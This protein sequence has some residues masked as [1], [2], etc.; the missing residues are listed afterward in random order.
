MVAMIDWHSHILPGMDDGSRSVEE[1]LG[2]VAMQAAQGIKTVIATPH[3]YAN[4]E[5]VE[6]FLSRRQKAFAEL[7]ANLPE[8]SPEILLGAEIRYYPGIS[9]M[10]DLEALGIGE[11]NLLLLEMPM[12]Q[13]TEYSLRELIELSGRSNLQI[14]LAHI[15]R[16]LK[17]QK[18]AM[19]EQLSETGIL[20]QANASFFTSALRKRKAMSMLTEGC[21][22]FI[23]SDGHNLTSRPPRLQEAFG[24]IE[25]KLGSEYV[26]QMNEY[27]D[28]MLNNKR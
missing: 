23:G 1:S 4:D 25:K 26:N 27:G 22:H 18:Q 7:Q 8:N 5:P 14:V 20:L 13:W 28:T 11:S 6:T 9:H 19:W 2:M 10:E 21:I 17:W 15:D 16:Y 24:Q 12:S 3:F